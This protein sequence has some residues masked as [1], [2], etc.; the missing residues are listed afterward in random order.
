[1]VHIACISAVLR[2]TGSLEGRLETYV[3][4]FRQLPPSRGSGALIAHEH[5]NFCSSVYPQFHSNQCKIC[6][7]YISLPPGGSLMLPDDRHRWG[8]IFRALLSHSH[9]DSA[10]SDGAL[11]SKPFSRLPQ[12]VC[13]KDWGGLFTRHML[14]WDP[15]TQMPLESPQ[16]I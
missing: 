2:A 8:H 7:K 14:C 16:N 12:M 1:M 3:S 13:L 15:C 4:F 5:K 11:M 9:A 10:D 6:I